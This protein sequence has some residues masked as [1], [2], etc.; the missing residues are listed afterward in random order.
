MGCVACIHAVHGA[1]RKVPG[2]VT[3]QAQLYTTGAKQGGSATVQW[4]PEMSSTSNTTT[5]NSYSSLL[6]AVAD[7]GFSGATIVQSVPK[8]VTLSTGIDE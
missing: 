2:V 4:L 6:Q 7:A 3:A 1:L 8:T 5:L